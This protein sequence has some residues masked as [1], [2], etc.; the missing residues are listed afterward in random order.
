MPVTALLI[1]LL[2]MVL[3]C[4]ICEG[5]KVR[6]S[7]ATFLTAHMLLIP[8]NPIHIITYAQHMQYPQ[9]PYHVPLIHMNPNQPPAVSVFGDRQ[10]LSWPR[11]TLTKMVPIAKLESKIGCIGLPRAPS[12][13]HVKFCAAVFMRLGNAA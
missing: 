2:F 11:K 10:K 1:A 7:C 9:H 13:R 5:N 4:V 6:C 12:S 3:F 8:Q